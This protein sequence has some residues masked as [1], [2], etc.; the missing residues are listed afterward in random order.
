MELNGDVLESVRRTCLVGAPTTTGDDAWSW[1]LRPAIGL[2]K[3]IGARLILADVSTRAMWTTPYGSGGA[4][5]DRG[6]PYSDGTVAVSR[7]ELQLLGHAGLIEQ[8]DEAKD[9]GVETEMWLAEG[10]GVR[11]LDRFLELFPIQV[12]IVPPFDDPSLA[13]RIRGDDID[14][15]RRRMKNR[16]LL[17]ADEEGT[18]HLD[19]G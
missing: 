18:I 13:D 9:A 12:L 2:A 3:E 5:A 1:A 8:L 15:V 17:I 6:A 4:G 14:A 10:P 7:A 16:I 19:R 11:A